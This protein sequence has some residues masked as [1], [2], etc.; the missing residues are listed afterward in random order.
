MSKQTIEIGDTGEQFVSKLK[1]NFDELYLGSG[2][3]GYIIQESDAISTDAWWESK[4]EIYN[5]FSITKNFDFEGRTV[6]L[7]PNI[8]LL[9]NGGVWSNG[10]I[11]GDNSVFWVY[12]NQQSFGTDLTLSG[13]WLVDKINV[14]NYGAVPNNDNVTYVNDSYAAIQKAFDS[15]FDV[16]IPAGC[17]YI[18]SGLT[19]SQPKT[20]YCSGSQNARTGDNYVYSKTQTLIYTDQN[21]HLLTIQAR[22]VNWLKG[23]F[24]LTGIDL[25]DKSAVRFDC[26]KNIFYCVIDCDIVGNRTSLIADTNTATGFL[27]D[28]SQSFVGNAETHMVTLLGSVYYCRYA[29][30][31]QPYNEDAPGVYV[32]YISPN[33]VAWGCKVMY[34]WES[35]HHSK[36]TGL[37]QA[38]S[39]L[40]LEQRYWAGIYIGQDISSVIV[41]VMEYDLGSS[42]SFPFRTSIYIENLSKIQLINDYV[43]YKKSRSPELFIDH[44]GI[45]NMI[46][47]ENPNTFKFFSNK[48][49][50]SYDTYVSRWDNMLAYAHLRS[51]VTTKKYDSVAL[52]IDFD[53]D[54]DETVGAETANITLYRENNVFNAIGDAA[55]YK[56]TNEATRLT[57]FVEITIDCVGQIFA[58]LS[59][60]Y[61]LNNYGLS[62]EG[63]SRGYGASVVRIQVIL[64]GDSDTTD[65]Y[66]FYPIISGQNGIVHQ[67]Y[68]PSITYPIQKIIIRFIGASTI[69]EEMLISEIGGRGVLLY[70]NPSIDIGG[71]QTIYGTLA[72]NDGVKETDLPVYADNA[73]AIAGGLEAGDP[74]RTSTGVRMVVYTP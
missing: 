69:N 26:T 19:I 32:S 34:K 29:C 58:Y 67:V 50:F 47:I 24:D 74:Y 7:P 9:F 62:G 15:L 5:T 51:T 41:D 40:T 22:N 16:E 10:E 72:V 49:A 23:T 2:G 17:F 28:N 27:F 43:S 63:G 59:Q 54:L 25:H 11:K 68:N 30:W 61:I 18:S 35:G 55:G 38:D 48:R 6:S 39:V 64:K 8:V 13:T 65:V 66:N 3:I 37:F 56:W 21:I 60:L 12:S 52:G 31:T 73:A 45:N 44:V 14:I 57:D 1:N 36:L 33:I 20:I 4:I 70:F 46:A 42:E 53:V 71:G